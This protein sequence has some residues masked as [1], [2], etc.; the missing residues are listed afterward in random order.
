[1]STVPLKQSENKRKR[2]TEKKEEE[3]SKESR[4]TRTAKIWVVDR[5]WVQHSTAAVAWKVRPLT[6]EL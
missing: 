1:V 3:K 4:S 2:R 6:S 5:S